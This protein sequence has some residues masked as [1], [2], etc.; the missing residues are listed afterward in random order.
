MR[1]AL[2][3]AANALLTLLRRPDP[4]KSWGQKIARKRGHKAA[5]LAV[6]RKLAVIL[7]AMWRDGTDYGEPKSGGNM[8]IPAR[9]IAAM[10]E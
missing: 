6:A 10:N 5:C 7:H 9:A 4:L 2:Y 1:T 3:E 8:S